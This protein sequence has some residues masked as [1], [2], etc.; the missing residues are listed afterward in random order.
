MFVVFELSDFHTISHNFSYYICFSWCTRFRGLPIPT[1][2][3]KIC[4]EPI[5]IYSQLIKKE[6]QS[7]VQRD[8][9]GQKQFGYKKKQQKNKSSDITQSN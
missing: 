2:I 3:T 6:A 4:I 5:K 7:Q 8:I 1:K 9:R